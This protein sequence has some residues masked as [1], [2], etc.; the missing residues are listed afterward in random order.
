MSN[1]PTSSRA[2]LDAVNGGLIVLDRA[3]RIVIWNAWMRLSSGITAEGARGKLLGEVF[4]QAELDRLLAAIATALKSGA[5]TIIT[6]ALN[7]SL[8]PLWTRSRQAL[9]HDITVSPI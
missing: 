8:L 7:A 3:G 2:I 9:L 6:H 5:S 1:S 4:P